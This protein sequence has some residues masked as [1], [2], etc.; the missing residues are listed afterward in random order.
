MFIL[1]QIHLFFEIHATKIKKFLGLYDD[2][3]HQE[4]LAIF[5]QHQAYLAK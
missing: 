4:I 1:Y 2:L 5:E 3:P